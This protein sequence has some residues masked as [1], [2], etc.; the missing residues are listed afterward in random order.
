M[1]DSF[2]DRTDVSEKKIPTALDKDQ[3]D[4]FDDMFNSENIDEGI[5]LKDKRWV[6]EMKEN[7]I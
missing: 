2:K 4:K 1:G 6:L 7:N 5:D 3:F